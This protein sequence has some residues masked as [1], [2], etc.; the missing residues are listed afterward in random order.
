MKT[1]KT[2]PKRDLTGL[3]FGN[4]KVVKFVG[5]S[6]S[7]PLWECE[8]SCTGKTRK[9]VKEYHLTNGQI[10]SCGCLRGRKAGDR[11]NRYDLSGEYGIGYDERGHKFLF[12]LEHFDKLKPFG[13]YTDSGGYFI[14]N[15]NRLIKGKTHV[16]LHHLI[17]GECP[18]GKQ[19]NHKN[20][21]RSDN[22]KSMLRFCSW[23]E[24]SRNRKVKGYHFNNGIKKWRAA[25][26][27]NGKT[28]HLGCFDTEE[29]AKQSRKAA[30][31]KYFGDFRY[32]PV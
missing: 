19:I 23:A 15:S 9:I 20:H 5:Y 12:D 25:I 29:E 6:G 3:L 1:K 2:E 26:E 18:E 4:L 16:Y 32:Q 31:I 10:K 27:L 21:D 14:T 24:I 22:R 8:C 11:K 17:M 28:I 7:F 13:W 30:E